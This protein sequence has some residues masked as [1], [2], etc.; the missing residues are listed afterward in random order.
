MRAHLRIARPV[1]DLER[2]VTQ[3]RRGLDLDDLG[4]FQDHEGF[5]GVILGAPDMA[6]HLEFTFCR[7]HPLRPTPTVDDLLVFYVPERAEW[8]Q[9]CARM[10]DA[11]FNEVS[12][13]N[14]YWQGRGR[15]FRDHDLYNVVLEQSAWRAGDEPRAT[16]GSSANAHAEAVER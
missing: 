4:R 6:Y 14:P 7:T 13:F 10:R 16:A 8:V 1:S 9:A 3:Y 5:D 15:S 2:S 12:P 11:G